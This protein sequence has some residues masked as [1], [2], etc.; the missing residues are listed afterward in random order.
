MLGIHRPG[1]WSGQPDDRLLALILKQRR[2]P[3][4]LAVQFDFDPESS[5]MTNG[6]SIDF[7][8]AG[9]SEMDNFIAEHGQIANGAKKRG[10]RR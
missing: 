8:R 5:L 4:F 3:S 2:G 6:R 9:A 1:L 7:P 10:K